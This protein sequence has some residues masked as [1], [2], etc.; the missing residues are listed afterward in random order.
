MCGVSLMENAVIYLRQKEME[1]TENLLSSADTYI[2][3]LKQKYIIKNVLFE[4]YNDTSQLDNFI[5]STPKNIDVFIMHYLFKDEF[6]L[7]V[8][9]EI[10]KLENFRIEYIKRNSS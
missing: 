2:S 3:K 1:S 7:T 4:S 8:L 9:N 6:N 5:N 10:S